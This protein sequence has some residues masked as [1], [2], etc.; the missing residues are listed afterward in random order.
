MT[1]FS[2]F[3]NHGHGKFIVQTTLLVILS[4]VAILWGWNTVATLFALPVVQFK[5]ALAVAGLV[6][7][8]AGPFRMFRRRERG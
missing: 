4:G 7:V 8:A 5:H 1:D 3:T 6:A 2:N